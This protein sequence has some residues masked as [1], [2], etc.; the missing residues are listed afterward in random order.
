MRRFFMLVSAIIVLA[1]VVISCRTL[2]GI[3]T[4]VPA[5]VASVAISEPVVTPIYIPPA[6]DLISLEDTLVEIYQKVNPG[7]VALRVLDEDGGSRGSGFVIDKEGHIITNYHVVEGVSKLEVAFPTGLKTR[8]EL[9]GTDLDS[10]IAVIKVDVPA[11]ELSPLTFSDSDQVRVGQTVIAI[12]NP[13]G[14]NGTMTMGIVSGLGRTMR[15]LHEAPEGGLFS[16]GDI[17]Q[18]DAAINPGNSG[19]PLLNLKGDV[20]GVNRAIYTNNFDDVGQPLNSGVGFAISINIIKRVIPS[21]IASGEYEYPYVGISSINDLSILEQEALGLAQPTGV[22]VNRV[23][24]GS[25]ADQAGIRGG[26][27]PTDLFGLE[28]GGDLIVAIDGSEVK[29]FAEFISYL[30]RNKS[31]GDDIVLTVLRG[32]EHFDISVTLDKRPSP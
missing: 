28:A 13:F 14:F 10:D 22:Y 8:A 4:D 24:P 18:T 3:S 19:G 5:P 7:V 21:L 15:S 6:V 30:L 29:T 17:I 16:S 32:E 27:R 23:T 31:P 2:P 25:P 20:I 12:G 9:L 1:M 26:D 11:E